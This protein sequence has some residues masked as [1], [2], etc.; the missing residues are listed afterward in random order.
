MIEK[1][2]SNAENIF[3]V[4]KTVVFGIQKIFSVIEIIFFFVEIT[5]SA[6]ENIFSSAEKT[7]G[8]V[9]ALLVAV[10]NEVK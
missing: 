9:P 4:S 6:S 10:T 3:S 7:A 1:I 8:A 2:F 5:I